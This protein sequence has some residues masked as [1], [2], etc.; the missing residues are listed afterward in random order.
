MSTATQAGKA[1]K[2]WLEY[3]KEYFSGYTPLFTTTFDFHVDSF[4]AFG[5]RVPY[6]AIG[7]Q[8]LRCAGIDPDQ[9]HY[10]IEYGNDAI[11]V[12]AY[13]KDYHN[14]R[15]PVPVYC[16]SQQFAGLRYSTVDYQRH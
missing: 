7:D 16:R 10:V 2:R 1:R 14:I 11:N 3:C 5:I 8:I 9:C 15:V 6:Q 4:G 12:I 13:D